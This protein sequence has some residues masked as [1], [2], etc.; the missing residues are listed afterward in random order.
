[1]CFPKEKASSANKMSCAS[2]EEFHDEYEGTG[3]AYSGEYTASNGE[4]QT[5]TGTMLPTLPATGTTARATATSSRGD[6][7]STLTATDA[8]GNTNSG[9]SSAAQT[10]TAQTQQGGAPTSA[11]AKCGVL[12]SMALSI[13]AMIVLHV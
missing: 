13:M 12:M 4:A 11:D 1:M 8:A 2:I 5:I 7:M 9:T 3:N 10:S 6:E